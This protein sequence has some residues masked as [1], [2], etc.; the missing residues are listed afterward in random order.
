M[1]QLYAGHMKPR[2][3]MP[4]LQRAGQI[5]ANTKDILECGGAGEGRNVIFRF[6]TITGHLKT[7]TQEENQ[8][9]KKHWQ[10]KT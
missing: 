7:K 8:V 4:G 5:E 10:L 6:L 1:C 9:K 3:Q 2:I